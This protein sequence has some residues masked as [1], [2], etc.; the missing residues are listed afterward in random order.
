MIAQPS[1]ATRRVIGRID[2]GDDVIANLARICDLQAIQAGEIRFFGAISGVEIV[3]PS[4][5]G[6]R[7]IET[8][9]ADFEIV[10]GV[11]LVSRLGN[12][13][14]VNIN[15]HLSTFGP[16][17]QQF[18]F[19]QLRAARAVDFEFIID[20]FEDVQID[21][22]LDA[23]SG[24]LVIQSI[25]GVE[26]DSPPVRERKAPE[27]IAE[28]KLQ[29]DDEPEKAKVEVPKPVAKVTPQ[30]VSEPEPEPSTSW[31]SAMKASEDMEPAFKRDKRKT[32][33]L[34]PRGLDGIEESDDSELMQPGDILHH[35][36]LGQ[37]RIVRVE[38]DEFAHIR[39]QRGQIR[40]LALTICEITWVEEEEGRNVFKLRIKK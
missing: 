4:A 31:K 13:T 14:V 7:P 17:G 35:P 37:C 25:D 23:T 40:K 8:G 28:A 15:A 21:R 29:K 36:K 30:P 27:R 5:Q 24:R 2:S 38:D 19:G 1:K 16:A 6:Y 20:V 10:N 33:K 12:Q 18:V 34:G 32:T 22:S 11:A 9:A 39:L 26:G 3:R